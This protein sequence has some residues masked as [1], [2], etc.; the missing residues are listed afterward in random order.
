MQGWA[1]GASSPISL[2]LTAKDVSVADVQQFAQSNYPVS[3]TIAANISLRGSEE[4]PQG[5]GSVQ[6]TQAVAWN[7]KLKSIAVNFSGDGST[8]HSTAQLS[9]PAG[10]LAAELSYQ[11]R[12]QS[13]DLVVK[14][15]GIKLENLQSQQVQSLGVSGSVA[16][17]ASGHGTLTNPQ[18]T[19]N[20]QIPQ[21]RVRDWMVSDIQAQLNTANQHANFVLSSKAEQASIQAKGDVALNGQYPAMA[22]LD[23][24]AIP[25]AVVLAKYLPANQNVQGQADLHADL[26]GP[27]KNPLAIA[28][29]IEI[30]N[31]NVAYQS[32]SLALVRPLK[33]NYA[34]GL[35]TLEEAD[36]Q[37]AGTN[38][39]LA[40]TIP[41][42]SAQPLNVS[43]NGTI[44]LALLQGFAP[45]VR[46]SGRLDVNLS[47]R[48]ALE[49]P[50]MQGQIH[51]VD[52]RLATQSAPVGLDGVNGLIQVSGN[53]IDIAQFSGSVG[54][55]TVAA[56]GFMT[57]GQ[58]SSFNLGMDLKSVRLRYPEGIRSILSGN[59]ALNGSPAD[60]HLTGRVLVDRLS[61]TQ[62]FDLANFLGQFSS[63][64]PTA[65]SSPL[66]RGMKLNV[67]IAT[68]EEVSLANSKVS[69]RR[70][71]RTL[72][73]ISTA[74]NPVVL[75]RTSLT[76]GDI[77]LY[78]QKRCQ[79]QNGTIEFA[80]PIRTTP[81]L[82]LNV[83]TTVQQYNIGLNFV[84][85]LN[86]LR[87][88]YTSDPPLPSA[89]II[90]L[91]AFGKTSEQAATSPSTPATL[92]AES[93]L[94]QGV[95]GQ[96]SNQIERLTGISQLT[97][98]PLAG[99]GQTNPGSRVAIQQRVSGS[100]L[101][102]FSTDVTTTQNESIQVQYQAKK[103]LSISVL[104]DQYG[105]RSGGCLP[106]AQK[107]F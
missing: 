19:A 7:E 75:G 50:A 1:F 102:T 77:F 68:T 58:P 29:Q 8:I 40:G 66:E 70:A 91:V 15:S 48:G 94:A 21:L 39:K 67:A 53:R 87:T 34:N 42:K 92:G 12:T 69:V 32:T 55:G 98:D 84:G 30:P 97:I 41:V 9:A 78:G 35:A 26:N 56:H 104:R 25:M 96:V 49:H 27:L 18:L 88:N 65:A 100:I 16:L 24:H 20:L 86:R 47:A 52:A 5:Q 60:S 10:D 2:Q 90:N 79:I 59:V 63:E 45:D 64:A 11:P 61:F 23:V 4:N 33:L 82:N 38:F 3:G 99:N 81:V 89:D 74:A 6:I 28:A 62:Q 83:T 17:S 46:S 31:L 105:G 43:A 36:F 13:Y 44:D 85:P 101:L 73:L 80:N 72:T 37:G 54:G 14:S 106:G 71:P 95:T 76:G 93:V 51:L 22:S 103:N 107:V 57:Y